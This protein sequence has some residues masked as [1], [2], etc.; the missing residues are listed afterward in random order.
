MSINKQK[1][2]IDNFAK[3]YLSAATGTTD[4]ALKKLNK[5]RV[6]IKGRTGKTRSDKGKNAKSY[7]YVRW[8]L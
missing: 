4:Y 6:R 5:A 2:F 8:P 1:K 3:F 7:K